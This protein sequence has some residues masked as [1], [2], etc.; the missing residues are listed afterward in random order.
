MYVKDLKSNHNKPF[1][2]S[3]CFILKDLL[4]I[5]INWEVYSLT[6]VLE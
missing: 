1:C 5:Y 3:S 6:L 4:W 2:P